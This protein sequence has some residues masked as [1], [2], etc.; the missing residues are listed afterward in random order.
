M[1]AH[2]ASAALAVHRACVMNVF[3][4]GFHQE[5]DQRMALSGVMTLVLALGASLYALDAARS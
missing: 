5:G 1:Y 3:H 2:A 4:P